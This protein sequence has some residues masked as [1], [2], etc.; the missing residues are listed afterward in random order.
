MNVFFVSLGCDKNLVDSEHMLS[1]LQQH[2]YDICDDESIADA[3]VINSCCF[4]KDAMEESIDTIIEMGKYKT[5]GRCKALILCGCL[6][7]RFAEEIP[8]ELPEVDGIIGTNSYDALIAVLDEVFAGHKTTV[9]KE[10]SGLPKNEGRLISAGGYSAYLK[11][12]EGCDKHCSYCIIPKIRGDFRSVPMEE[13]LEEAQ[14]LA[15][16]GVKE[17]VL[18]AQEVTVYGS[19]LY[20]KKTLPTLLEKL[21]EIEGIQWIRL[22]YCYPEEITPELIEV[23]ATNPKICHYIDM[24][25][26]HISNR[27]LGRMGRR[28]SQQD[29]Y[30]II[31]A[32]RA[33]IPD[34]TLRTTLICGFPGETEEDHQELMAFIKTAAFDRLGAFTYSQ[35]DGTVAANFPDQVEDVIKDMWYND[36]MT[37]QQEITFAK[38][39]TLIGQTME[40]LIEGRMS[41]EDVYVGRTYRDAPSV[42]GYVFVHSPREFMSGDFVS[43]TITAAKDYDLIG[44]VAE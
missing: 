31:A 1:M 8:V 7:Q 33:R 15:A 20:G 39:D 32:L 2:G 30:D 40:V 9:V 13:L 16:S 14:V 36:V 6:A 5:E 10:L 21:S 37:A 27:I 19:D 43:V 41:G 35:E 3:I 22:L 23:M 28:T 26:Q 24:P 25:I 17:L 44:D 12:A 42:D 29:I 38:N 18:V 4:I 34:I 11:I